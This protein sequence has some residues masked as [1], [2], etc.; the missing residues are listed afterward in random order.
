MVEMRKQLLDPHAE[1]PEMCKN[2]NLLGESGW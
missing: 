1:P 2:C